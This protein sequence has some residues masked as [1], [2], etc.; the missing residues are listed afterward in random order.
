MKRV[1]S[2]RSPLLGLAL[3]GFLALSLS[4]CG[5]PATVQDCEQIVARVTELELKQASIT[6][7]A[8]VQEQVAN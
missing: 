3:L 2:N 6:D 1:L 5:R 4:G 8:I 7:P